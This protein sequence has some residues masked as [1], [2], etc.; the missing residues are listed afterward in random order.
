MS[1]IYANIFC[2]FEGF[3][4]L[5]AVPGGTAD[6]AQVGCRFIIECGCGGFCGKQSTVV[7]AGCSNRCN[8]G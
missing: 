7:T 3:S 6:G 2:Q 4:H 5:W 1:G 8:H